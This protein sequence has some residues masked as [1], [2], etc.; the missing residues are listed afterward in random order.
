[1][2][3]YASGNP[4][5]LI[6]PTGKQDDRPTADQAA[7]NVCAID[8]PSTTT[9]SASTA[10][11]N[12]DATEDSPN[13]SNALTSTQSTR[14]GERSPV[15]S[16]ASSEATTF[17]ASGNSGVNLGNRN[18]EAVLRRWLEASPDPF[19][20]QGQTIPLGIGKDSLEDWEPPSFGGWLMG[21]LSNQFFRSLQEGGPVE[22][23]R[24]E[25]TMFGLPAKDLANMLYAVLVD[26]FFARVEKTV[27]VA[28][29][30][31]FAFAGAAVGEFSLTLFGVRPT[32]WITGRDL[33][34]GLYG[35]NLFQVVWYS[36]WPVYEHIWGY[37]SEPLTL[38]QRRA[39][40]TARQEEIN[41]LNRNIYD[42]ENR[43]NVV[44]GTMGWW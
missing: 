16:S 10:A 14:S 26:H 24:P 18:N 6:D 13:A 28:I 36:F 34:T 27:M 17:S 21:H 44:G 2:Y 41:K 30:E 11:A 37:E 40:E 31:V 39:E 19:G 23:D 35:Y 42:P 1:M 43:T 9:S 15:S 7:A 29:G 4:L 12:S 22:V 5:R 32:E 3:S 33:L 20:F 38:E 25:A 8:P